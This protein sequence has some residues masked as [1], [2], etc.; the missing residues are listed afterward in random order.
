[1]PWEKTTQTTITADDSKD[2]VGYAVSFRFEGAELQ[3]FA[4]ITGGEREQPAAEV[5]APLDLV[6]LRE[7]LE[8]ARDHVAASLGYN[9]VP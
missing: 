4:R 3:C 5:F 2:G 8:V 6:K 9:K 7:L 1:M